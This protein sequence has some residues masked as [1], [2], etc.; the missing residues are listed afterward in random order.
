MDPRAVPA[1]PAPVRLSRYTFGRRSGRL[2]VFRGGDE[3]VGCRAEGAKDLRLTRCSATL[4][5]AGRT[6]A[7][8]ERAMRDRRSLKVD[9][10][11]TRSGR[12]LLRRR[13]RGTDSIGRERPV[14]RRVTFRLP[15]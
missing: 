6:V 5:A 14:T 8:G 7:K 15:R 2:L 11:L 4:R 12:A 1:R 10:D 3:N 9:A 13:P